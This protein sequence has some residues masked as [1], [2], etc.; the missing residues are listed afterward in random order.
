M[1]RNAAVDSVVRA[2]RQVNIQGSLFG[3]TVA[4]RLGLSESD[5]EALEVLIDNGAA[6]AGRLADRMGLSTGAVTRL[7]D[8]LEQSGYV[9]RV[10]DPAD[11]RRVVVEVVPDRLADIRPLLDRVGKASS[12]EVAKYTDAQ[13]ELISDF[14]GK[15]ADLTRAEAVK[16]RETDGDTPETALHGSSVAPVGGLT[17]ARLHF[18]SGAS[19]VR[20]TGDANLTELYHATFEG[21]VPQVRLRA[22]VVTIQYHGGLFDWRRRKADIALATGV[23]WDIS[24]KGGASK[25]D[26]DFRAIDLRSFDLSGGT[27]NVDMHLGAPKGDIGIRLVGGTSSLRIDRP[28]GVPVRVTVTGGV[29]RLE[30]DGQSIGSSGGTRTVETDGA[31]ARA[32]RFVVDIVGSASKVTISERKA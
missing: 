4:I 10:S 13:L 31:G 18:R 16:V 19:E 6:T 2:L 32:D 8:R 22:G 30:F 29:S 26:A 9:R 5:V 17:Q 11:R 25:M 23:A 15:M 20:L 7:I 28:R 27:S 24:V 21:A 12:Q 14:L 1:D 3:Q